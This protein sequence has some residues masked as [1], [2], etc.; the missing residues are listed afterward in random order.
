[1]AHSANLFDMGHLMVFMGPP[2]LVEFSIMAI[3]R[4]TVFKRLVDQ[5]MVEFII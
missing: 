4:L 2:A 3:I 1:M 5:R